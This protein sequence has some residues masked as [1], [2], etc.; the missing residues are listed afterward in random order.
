MS[1]KT[2]GICERIIHRIKSKELHSYPY[3]TLHPQ[4]FS[5]PDSLWIRS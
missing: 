4:I 2:E 1:R 5:S 3:T